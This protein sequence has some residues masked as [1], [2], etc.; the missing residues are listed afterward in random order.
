MIRPHP[1]RGRKEGD[2]LEGFRFTLRMKRRNTVSVTP[3][4]GA[5]TVAGAMRTFPIWKDSGTLTW[6]GGVVAVG[7]VSSTCA[8]PYSIVILSC[9]VKIGSLSDA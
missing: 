8:H 3:A 1:I 5:S 6:A 4:I 2:R 7:G 9:L